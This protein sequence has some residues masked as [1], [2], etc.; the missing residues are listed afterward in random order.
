MIHNSV[1]KSG[2]WF[3]GVLVFLVSS[4]TLPIPASADSFAAVAETDTQ[5]SNGVNLGS[6]FLAYFGG[7]GGTNNDGPWM[8]TDGRTWTQAVDPDIHQNPETMWQVACA[9]GGTAY[10]LRGGTVELGPPVSVNPFAVWS[11]TDGATWSPVSVNPA[12]TS[13]FPPALS[14]AFYAFSVGSSLIIVNAHPIVTS[15]HPTVWRSDNGGVDWTQVAS[16]LFDYNIVDHVAFGPEVFIRVAPDIN[17]PAGNAT[18]YRSSDGNTWTQVAG[19]V[20]SGESVSDIAVFQGDLYAAIFSQDSGSRRVARSSDGVAWLDVPGFDVPF[21]GFVRLSST[22]NILAANCHYPDLVLVSED[23]AVWRSVDISV[24]EDEYWVRL[25]GSFDN[26]VFLYSLSDSPAP[27]RIWRYEPTS[28][29]GVVG[30]LGGSVTISD[31]SDPAVGAGVILPKGAL[32]GDVALTVAGNTGASAPAE[33][34]ALLM[35]ADYGPEDLTF[36]SPATIVLPYSPEDLT[37][38]GA[39]PSQ[40]TV[41]DY[42]QE[43]TVADVIVDTDNDRVMAQVDHF[44]TYGLIL[45]P[46]VPAASGI[47]IASALLAVTCLVRRVLRSS[48]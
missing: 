11:S 15:Y 2:S 13:G 12:L 7:I 35:A 46:P 19:V 18:L 27:S 25:L 4:W 48:R 20:Q 22:A 30:A 37:A 26:A 38:M 36:D 28:G 24:F 23:G 44:S 43:I 14:G 42:E 34:L 10:I 47:W 31:P 40:L 1:R 41:W 32:T 17:N 6:W 9:V 45:V 29:T 16:P 33:S 21:G 39:R 5:L 3:V 8:T